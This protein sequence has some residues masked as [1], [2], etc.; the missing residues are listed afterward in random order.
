MDFLCRKEALLLANHRR[1]SDETLEVTRQAARTFLR[2][3]LGHFGRAFAGRVAAEDDGFFGVLGG[4]F[5]RFLDRECARAGV[6]AGPA[7]LAVR[8]DLVDE[9]PMACGTAEELIQI[10]RRR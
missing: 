10:Q 8:P 1:V 3:H 5:L 7:D 2:E 4:I 6:E 9:A